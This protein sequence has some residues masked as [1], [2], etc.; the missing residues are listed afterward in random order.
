MQRLPIALALGTFLGFVMPVQAATLVNVSLFDKGADTDM[1]TGLSYASGMSDMGKANVGIKLSRETVPAG[2]ITLKVENN[3]KEMVH[4]MV[5]FYL[6]DPTK[7][8]P[9]VADEN[10]ID[11]E[12][13]IDK[14]EVSELDPG[15]AG[16]VSLKLEPGKYLLACNVPGHFDAACGRC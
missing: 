1:A 15:K 14:G 7:P 11:E 13:A 6:K 4:E 2:E 9:Y 12:K 8:L 3:S 5:V 16:T 10:R